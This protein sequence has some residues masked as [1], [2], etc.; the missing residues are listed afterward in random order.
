M[1]LFEHWPYTNFHDLNLDWIIKKLPEVFTASAQAKQ[2]AETAV[3]AKDDAVAAKEAAQSSAENAAVSEENA[4]R[5]AGSA[6]DYAEH[7]ADPVGGLVTGWLEDNITPT[8]PPIDRSLTVQDAAADAKAAGDAIRDLQEQLSYIEAIPYTVKN[9]MDNLFKWIPYLDERAD[10][11]YA[12]VHAWAESIEATSI[13]AVFN[14][15]A[16]VVYTTDSLDSLRPFL[17][18]TAHYEDGGS[19]TVRDYTL[20]GDLEEGTS[21]ITVTY[22]NLT[23]T[24]TVNVTDATVDITDEFTFTTGGSI[25]TDNGNATST[26]SQT[27]AYS[28][29]VDISGYSRLIITMRKLR[30]APNVPTG[31]AFYNS[32]RTF[33]SGS[34]VPETVDTSMDSITQETRNLAIPSNAVYV[35]TTWFGPE[36][37]FYSSA[38]FSC[39]GLVE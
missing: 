1:G 4:E 34:G 33:I 35:R 17:T 20:S 38:E 9:A 25:R 37:G 16:H 21:T 15:G 10:D 24:F 11:Y 2:S 19:S 22:A 27:V 8:T 7:I 26:S 32:S 23:T 6:Q 31:L 36:S 14:Q 3:S 29:Y 13:S 18:V 39:L 28:D 30:T 12:V 5:S